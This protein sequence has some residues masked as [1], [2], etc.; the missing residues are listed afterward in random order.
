M[1]LW[2]GVV[3]FTFWDVEENCIWGV[4]YIFGLIFFKLCVFL[5]FLLF[6]KVNEM[7]IA[8]S[9]RDHIW[10][11]CCIISF[12]DLK[13]LCFTDFTWVHDTKIWLMFFWN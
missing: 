1:R 2:E 8:C 9:S 11:C 13:L 5:L 3:G 7:E 6:W 10:N 4:D 12:V